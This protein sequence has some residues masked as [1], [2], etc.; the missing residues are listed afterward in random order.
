MTDFFYCPTN[1]GFYNTDVYAPEHMPT[2]V[3]AIS[4]ERYIEL[5]DGQ[6]GLKLIVV[7]SSGM[8]VLADVAPAVVDYVALVASTRYER[9]T[10]GINLDGMAID[11][12]RDSQGLITG[13]VVQA[14]L[15][16]GYVL[17]WKTSAGFVQLTARQIIGVASAV[18]AHV[19]ACFDREA[20]LLTSL[21]AGSFRPAMLNQGWPV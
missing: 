6:S 3:I 18:R 15:E 8:P 21:E 11:T 17:R 10:A 4:K 20:V 16:P 2:D 9:E 13:A 19:Q 5:R 1:N 14:M 12:G 7:D